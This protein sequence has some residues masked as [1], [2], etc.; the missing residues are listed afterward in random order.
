MS[1]TVRTTEATGGISDGTESGGGSESGGLENGV[2]F[3]SVSKQPRLKKRP[4]L[5]IPESVKE[6][7]I[8][9]TVKIV[10]DI[11]EKGIVVA[12]R[13]KK[14]L[15]P[16]ADAACLKSWKKA[17]FQPAQQDGTPVGVRNFPRRCRYRAM[18]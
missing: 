15:D 10:I 18:D 17:T 13:V 16:E 14:S 9:G 3:A 12:A 7:G 2:S 8:E 11:D 1:N 4:P 5:I 6:K